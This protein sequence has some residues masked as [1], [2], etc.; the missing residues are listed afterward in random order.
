MPLG[1]LDV[2]LG[3]FSGAL[4]QGNLVSLGQLPMV[5]SSDSLLDGINHVP[6]NLGFRINMALFFVLANC[7]V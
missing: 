4:P 6:C 5:S 1:G 2:P 3:A 7:F